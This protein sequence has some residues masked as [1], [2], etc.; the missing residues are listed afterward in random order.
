METFEI[1]TNR[2]K[3]GLAMI[4]TLGHAQIKETKG[5]LE[6]NT[7]TGKLGIFIDIKKKIKQ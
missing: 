7:S 2:T 1:T 3:R 4:L 6:K 5:L